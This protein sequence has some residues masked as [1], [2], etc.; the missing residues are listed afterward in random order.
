ML[1][2]VSNM[3]RRLVDFAL[4]PLCLEEKHYIPYSDGRRICAKCKNELIV[5]KL[6][7]L[8]SEYDVPDDCPFCGKEGEE[9]DTIY[10]KYGVVVFKCKKCGRFDGYKYNS[11]DDD[12]D[13]GFDLSDALYPRITKKIAEKEG[14]PIMSASTVRKIAEEINKKAKNPKQKCQDQ[15]TI[16]IKEKRKALEEAKVNREVLGNAY[17]QTRYLIQKNGPYT[18]KQ[19]KMV[20]PAAILETQEK[21]LLKSGI[22]ENRATERRMM[23]IFGTA[24]KTIRKWK[25]KLKNIG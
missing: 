11:E 17:A 10:E 6:R 5:M 23:E 13:Y 8:D 20:L 4:C 15:L 25:K 16:L 7:L 19:L 12:W 22:L 9:D 24:R 2:L 3:M 18:K 21:L 1:N 14:K